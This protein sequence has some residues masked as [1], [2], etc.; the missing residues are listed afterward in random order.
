VKV[1]EGVPEFLGDTAL[2]VRLSSQGTFDVEYSR[3]QAIASAGVLGLG[4]H[5][6][7][8]IDLAMNWDESDGE[9]LRVVRLRGDR[10]DP[11]SIIGDGVRIA[12]AYRV[13]LRELYGA[14]GALPLPDETSACGG[15]MRVFESMESY[16]RKVL[17]AGE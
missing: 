10:F 7:V 16:Q 13:L 9:P 4:E 12:E 17:D 6:V 14:T 15:P 1:I 2:Q 8:I 3:V 11:R 5:P